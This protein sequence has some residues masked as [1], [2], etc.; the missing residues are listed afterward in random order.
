MTIRMTRAAAQAGFVRGFGPGREVG[1]VM[2][3]QVD[4]MDAVAR[5]EMVQMVPDGLRE[6]AG[7][8][9][10][11]GQGDVGDG[12]EQ[13]CQVGVGAQEAMGEGGLHGGLRGGGGAGTMR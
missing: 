7:H 6:G 12:V 11:V 1:R 5:R 10:G 13:G 4:V 2:V 8:E 9:P 3:D